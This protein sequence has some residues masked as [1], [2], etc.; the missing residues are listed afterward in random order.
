[1]PHSEGL[2][3]EKPLLGGFVRRGLGLMRKRPQRSAQ[4]EGGEAGA[5]LVAGP[6]GR[7]AQA[8]ASQRKGLCRGGPVV[9]REREPRRRGIQHSLA[10][11]EQIAKV[12]AARKEGRDAEGRRGESTRRRSLRRGCWFCHGWKVILG[13]RS[14]GASHARDGCQASC[15]AA[16]QRLRAEIVAH[17]H[18]V[19]RNRRLQVRREKRALQPEGAPLGELV[20]ARQGRCRVPATRFSPQHPG[21]VPQFLG[22]RARP[23]AAVTESKQPRTLR[24]RR[25]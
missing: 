21:E 18:R 13:Q 15:N 4:R 1:M 7:G 19:E 9:P 5:H 2:C 22:D 6:L 14:S 24:R 11:A 8:K 20:A 3:R 10:A 17:D 12:I 23:R 16:R 25:R